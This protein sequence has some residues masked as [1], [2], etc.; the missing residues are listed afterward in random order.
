MIQ[1]FRHACLIVSNLDK[2]LEFYRDFLGLKVF[3]KLTIEGEY[4]QAAFNIKGLR[5]TYVK[6]HSPNQSQDS[7]PVF[8]GLAAAE[9]RL[10]MATVD[11][12]LQCFGK[13]GLAE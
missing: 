1:D 8:D 9:D 2:S 13:S 3:K 4:P 10:F 5:L 12:T 7:P 11:G 6:M